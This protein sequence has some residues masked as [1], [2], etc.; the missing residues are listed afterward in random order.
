MGFRGLWKM[1]FS[2]VD[3]VFSDGFQYRRLGFCYRFGILLLV[4]VFT[5]RFRRPSDSTSSPSPQSAP[6]IG[7]SQ[8]GCSFCGWVRQ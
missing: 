1:G 5:A 3:W 6:S 4:W 2:T 8:M 7:S